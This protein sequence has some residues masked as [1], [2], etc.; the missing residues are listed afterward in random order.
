MIL[1]SD[2]LKTIL[3]M[4][5]VAV[6]ISGCGSN[7]SRELKEIVKEESGEKAVEESK[8]ESKEESEQSKEEDPSES[9]E[10]GE[11]SKSNIT[12]D[13]QV[14]VEQD[15]IKITALEYVSD[16]I[17][18]DGIKTLIENETDKDVNVG[19]SALIVNDYMITDLF[20]STVA[21]GKKS[22][23]TIYLS[24]SEL[25]AAGI[26]TV[27]QIEIYFHVYEADNWEDLFDTD[28]I[29]IQTS[30]YNE[31]DTT[32]DESGNE[33]YNEN[34]IRIVGKAVDENSFWGTAILLYIENNTNN[35]IMV[36]VDDASINGFMITPYFSSN[37][38]AG[39]KAINDISIMSSDLEAN[40]IK[41]VEDVELK[42]HITN[43]DTYETI[44]E[45]DVVSFTTK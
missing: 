35:N 15:G 22:N 5:A 24:S 23:D 8:E 21:A 38:Y 28:G 42:F 25:K 4:T 41:S 7:S 20:A 30:A 34:G 36:S 27:G 10:S 19:C 45:S 39:K 26:D 11:E 6:L 43:S 37:V 1:K 2:F 29:T 31:M 44:T 32:P 12:I 17:W 40:G 33:L 16:S 18:G 13:E 14:L 3:C 9:D